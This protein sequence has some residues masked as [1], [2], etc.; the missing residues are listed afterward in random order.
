MIRAIVFIALW[1]LAG[2]ARAAPAFQLSMYPIFS[3]GAAFGCPALSFPEG[4]QLLVSV[5]AVGTDG[6]PATDYN[7]TVVF[8]ST[9]PSAVIVPSS[10][11]FV[12]SDHGITSVAVRFYRQ[13]PQ[14]IT[15]ADAI[16]G[17]SGSTGASINSN[18]LPKITNA[19]DLSG[20]WSAPYIGGQGIMLDVASNDDGSANVFGAWFTFTD[21]TTVPQA[22]PVWFSFQGKMASLAE[23]GA[24]LDIYATPGGNFNAGPVVSA[25]LIGRA[26]LQF[27]GC[28]QAQF[29]FLMANDYL[30]YRKPDSFVAGSSLNLQR[31]SAEAGCDSAS[32]PTRS[33]R[34]FSG[35]WYDPSTSG[36]GLLFDVSATNG[37]WLFGGWFTFSADIYGGF[38]WFTLQGPFPLNGNEADVPIYVA[39]TE[40][41]LSTASPT[42]GETSTHQVGTAH[43]L[44]KSCTDAQLDFNFQ[45]GVNATGSIPL[46]RLTPVPDDCS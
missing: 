38:Q 19:G 29:S 40:S 13:G 26:T 20:A 42:N 21:L 9:D 1:T 31:L 11:T 14:T 28:S 8:T 23:A 45:D 36:Q 16:N 7:G 33:A 41:F 2:L 43:I 15:G 24:I 44:F 32:M 5:E 46:K 27:Y 22:F 35:T 34:G 25:K 37:G 4:Y 17:L 18:S 10:H 30:N 3:C 6:F 12:A 39:R